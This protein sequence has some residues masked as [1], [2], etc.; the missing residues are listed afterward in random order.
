ME[1][2]LDLMAA[3]LYWRMLVRGRDLDDAS[4]HRLAGSLTAALAALS[5]PA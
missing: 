5:N 3:P 1:L 2:A 4:I